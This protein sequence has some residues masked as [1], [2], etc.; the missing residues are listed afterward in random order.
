[1]GMFYVSTRRL[2]AL[3]ACLVGVVAVVVA[4][5]LSSSNGEVVYVL[6]GGSIPSSARTV[7]AV[8]GQPFG[9]CPDGSDC[10][11]S[12]WQQLRVEFLQQ[13]AMSLDASS[14]AGSVITLNDA[15]TFS[16]NLPTFPAIDGGLPS[17]TLNQLLVET[18]GGPA[19]ANMIGDLRCVAAG[20]NYTCTLV[21]IQGTP[22][23]GGGVTA[24]YVLTAIDG[25]ISWQAAAVATYGADLYAC[26]G[27]QCVN[28]I[29]PDGGNASWPVV[30]A[31]GFRAWNGAP[32]FGL[33]YGQEAG[34]SANP[35]SINFWAQRP[36]SAASTGDAGSPGNINENLYHPVSTG[37]WPV[38]TVTATDD[39]SDAGAAVLWAMGQ[40]AASSPTPPSGW[41]W[42]PLA[43]GTPRTG[44]NWAMYV[45]NAGGNSGTT[46]FN[47][48]TYMT[49]NLGNNLYSGL[50]MYKPGSGA[51]TAI[52]ANGGAVFGESAAVFGPEAVTPVYGILPAIA[53][54]ATTPVSLIG[55]SA[56][57]AASGAHQN[58]GNVPICGGE[59]AG[60]TGATDGVV[61]RG[62]GYTV[63]TY[64]QCNVTATTDSQGDLY[65]SAVSTPSC[66][67]GKG[68]IGADSSGNMWGCDSTGSP[69]RLNAGT[70]GAATGVYG[71]GLDGAFVLD[72]STDYS[73]AIHLVSSN[74]YQ[75]LVDVF[76]TTIVVNS[77]VFV[78]AN[79]YV[80]HANGSITVNSGGVLDCNSG[81][82]GTAGTS[83]GAGGTVGNSHGTLAAG[84]AGGAGGIGLAGS[85]GATTTNAFSSLTGPSNGGAGGADG[86]NAGG[87]PSPNTGI[88]G[89][90]L[91]LPGAALGTFTG[92]NGGS[93]GIYQITGGGGGGGG[94]A[95]LSGTGGG[96]G[97]S[98][99]LGV[100][101][102][103]T[104]VNSG[105]IQSIGG[106]GGAGTKA[107]GGGGGAG[108][109]IYFITNNG[110]S[111]NAPNVA[112]GSGGAGNSGGANGSSGA[113][114]QVVYLGP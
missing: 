32:S 43:A 15:G 44:S 31:A 62:S 42:G 36:N 33:E 76:A 52:T 101:A 97:G 41:L 25:G 3:L 71:N 93:W 7:G 26:D 6:D 83:G 81:A 85:N 28:S 90:T 23:D 10:A 108:G 74:L 105:I 69:Y 73:P 96:G 11:G 12:T 53:D 21:G 40:L 48:A 102:A 92:Y 84:W 64:A 13:I 87:L 82:N 104:I 95:A 106:N 77:G 91:S 99:G 109:L 86:A 88:G 66:V 37:V 16:L 17:G 2:V 19:F 47:A 72:G 75:T 79:G 51:P 14:G 34:A 68:R 38:W 114:G 100:L 57:S 9:N 27:G 98:A 60:L 111:G 113:A 112:G 50:V 5:R 22:L 59:H 58:A 80:L 78:A 56:Y 18:S 110:F 20:S 103:P 89:R 65:Q 30:N 55:Q 8:P 1:M 49:F 67:S 46:N 24:N 35:G 45:S 39:T 70:S 54:Y 4:C 63:T 61:T 107:G 94:G 29:T